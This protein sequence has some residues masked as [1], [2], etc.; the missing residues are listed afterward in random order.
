MPLHFRSLNE[1]DRTYAH[2]YLSPHLDDAALSCGG[3]ISRFA[4]DGQAVLVVNIGSGSPPAGASFSR[5]AAEQHAKWKLSPNE[6]M[7][8]RLREDIEALEILGADSLQLDLLDAIY[9]MPDAYHTESTLF[10]SLAADDPLPA[11]LHAVLLALIERCP[12][13]IV[14]APLGVGNH[15]DHQ[16]V[17]AAAAQLATS[18]TSIVYY[19]DFP[20]AAKPGA[21][22]RRLADLGGRQG[23]LPIIT[24]IGATIERKISA[25][26]AYASQMQVLFGGVDAMPGAVRAY[27]ESLQPEGGVYGERIWMRR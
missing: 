11:D 14:Y 20:Y 10:G 26:A 9:R 27:G 25:I 4:G 21:L 12:E 3:A 7:A 15:V 1:L 6:A 16:V 13:A 5:F 22:D 17:T 8:R 2:I 24:A 19:E 23:F 18:G